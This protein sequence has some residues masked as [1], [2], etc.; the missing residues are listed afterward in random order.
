[1]YLSTI[2]RVPNRSTETETGPGLLTGLISQIYNK[3]IHN[4]NKNKIEIASC[5]SWMSDWLD[6]AAMNSIAC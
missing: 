2:P 5:K 6:I 3:L 4:F 1:M